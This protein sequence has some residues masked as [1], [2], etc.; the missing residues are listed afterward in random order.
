[1]KNILKKLSQLRRQGQLTRT[2]IY[3]LLS[4]V[5]LG[6]FLS[7]TTQGLRLRMFLSDMTFEAFKSPRNYRTGDKRFLEQV[8]KPGGLVVDVGANIGMISIR[9]AKLV[10]PTGRVIAIEPNPGIAPFCKENIRLNGLENVTVF[11]TALGAKEGMTSFN[12]DKSD[13]CSRVSDKGG[14]EV[15]ITLLDKVMEIEPTRDID[16]LKVDVEGYEF[17][18][19]EGAV[20][21]LARTRLIYIEVDASNYAVFGRRTDEMIDLLNYHGFDTF[22]CDD[23][24]GKW[25][26]VKGAITGSVNVIGK[27]RS[28]RAAMDSPPAVLASHS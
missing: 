4:N 15:P 13:D 28:E 16:L 22:V 6:R 1:M 7:F 2:M 9:S 27:K 10:G 5:G 12:C 11:Q 24:T 25:S 14:V 20:K 8:L 21:S 26:E 3:K 17:V 23:E 18:V 19:L